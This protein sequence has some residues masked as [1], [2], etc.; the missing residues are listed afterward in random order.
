MA[1]SKTDDEAVDDSAEERDDGDRDLM[2]ETGLEVNPD[3]GDIV[4][5]DEPPNPDPDD[6]PPDDSSDREES[7]EDEETPEPKDERLTREEKFQK[8]IDREVGKRK[9]TE[10]RLTEVTSDRDTLQVEIDDLRTAQAATGL[11]QLALAGSNEQIDQR[12]QFLEKV[13]AFTTENWDGYEGTGDDD[14]QSYTASEIR[15]RASEV[16]A[17]LRQIPRARQ[18]LEQKHEQRQSAAEIHPELKDSSSAMSREVKREMARRPALRTLPGAELI[19][20]DAFVQRKRREASGNGRGRRRKGSS[21][22]APS[23]ARPAPNRRGRGK[24]SSVLTTFAEGGYT[25][26]ALAKALE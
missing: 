1:K 12:E 25:E 16:R 22:A 3:T 4:D 14:D 18:L 23:D 17:E 15:Q 7:D 21:A 24:T 11:G 5:D 13:E 9:D 2:D 20:A 10:D 26:E 19:I 6:D 8:R